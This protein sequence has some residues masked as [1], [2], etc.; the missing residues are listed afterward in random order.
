M[1]TRLYLGSTEAGWFAATFS[2]GWSSTAVAKRYHLLTSPTFSIEPL[3]TRTFSCV[4]PTA[5]GMFFTPP[6]AAGNVLDAE[7]IGQILAK[8]GSAS[9]NIFSF[10][11]ISAWS[12]DGTTLRATLRAVSNCGPT[13]YASAALTNRALA[14]AAPTT[15][16]TTVDG[17][18]YVFE[19]GA[20]GFFSASAQLRFGTD[21]ASDLPVD[22]T[23]TSDLRPWIELP[24][25]LEFFPD[26]SVTKIGTNVTTISKSGSNVTRPT[27]SG[28]NVTRIAKWGRV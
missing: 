6:L 25:T 27:K 14:D 13:E 21:A 28:S 20:D 2:A 11:A 26:F 19:L 24:G 16:Y 5:I 4:T 17:D 9:H 7:F 23:S 12:N 10:C 1:A 22:E 8:E 3:T 15:T 18:R